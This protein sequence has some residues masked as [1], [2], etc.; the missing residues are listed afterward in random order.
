M[1]DPDDVLLAIQLVRLVRTLLH[2]LIPK[3]KPRNR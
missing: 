2:L 1:P 3:K